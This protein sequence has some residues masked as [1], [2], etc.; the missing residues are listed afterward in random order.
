MV[1]E[2]SA[3]HPTVFPGRLLVLSG[4]FGAF[5][6]A[7]P[8]LVFGG[9]TVS[10]WLLAGFALAGAAIGAL[11]GIA[12]VKRSVPR[13]GPRRSQR[14]T[15]AFLVGTTASGLLLGRFLDV[16]SVPWLLLGC[17]ALT[18]G[19]AAHAKVALSHRTAEPRTT[20]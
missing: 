3:G 19:W 1:G 8:W 7:C 9:A 13:Q 12:E 20:S 15:G 17:T 11:V 5:Y 14:S 6:L 18:T 2:T 16:S 10:M 4:G